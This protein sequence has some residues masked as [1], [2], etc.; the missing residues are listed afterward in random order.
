M[1]GMLFI[2]F[3]AITLSA[4][5]TGATF[6]IGSFDFKGSFGGDAA[7]LAAEGVFSAAVF[8]TTFKGGAVEDTTR[9]GSETQDEKKSRPAPQR[10]RQIVRSKT[11]LAD[12][13]AIFQ[14]SA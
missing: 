5:G 13:C 9:G 11:C 4:F 12:N 2:S 6:R 7:G 3:F 14:S 10:T 1:L 8:S